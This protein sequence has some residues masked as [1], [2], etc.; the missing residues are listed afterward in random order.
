M[1]GS[2]IAPKHNM[3]YS[4]ELETM[5]EN[6]AKGTNLKMEFKGYPLI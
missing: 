2:I 4:L 3:F 6:K 5:L 1:L